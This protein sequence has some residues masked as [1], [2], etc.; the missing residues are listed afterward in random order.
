MASA[1][2]TYAVDK[3]GERAAHVIFRAGGCLNVWKA[4]DRG[5]A[6]PGPCREPLQGRMPS[7]VA[8]ME[9]LQPGVECR[10]NWSGITGEVIEVLPDGQV[11]VQWPSRTALT[12]GEW[13]VP[14]TQGATPTPRQ[15]V[16]T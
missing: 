11:R 4:A 12:R 14:G 13:L 1:C 9:W 10:E 3:P 5:L 16:R 15:G 2:C 7:M 8:G 6:R